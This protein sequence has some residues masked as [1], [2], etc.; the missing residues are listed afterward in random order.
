MTAEPKTIHYNG[1]EYE[2][3]QAH[4]RLSTAIIALE[5]GGMLLTVDSDDKE[6]VTGFVLNKHRQE[7]IDVITGRRRLLDLEAAIDECDVYEVK[8]IPKAYIYSI[9]HNFISKKEIK[10]CGCCQFG[11]IW[12]CPDGFKIQCHILLDTKFDLAESEM[13]T[14]KFP[15]C[16]L[17]LIGV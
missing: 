14:Y 11:Q 7:V 15:A 12:E 4:T 6:D 13:E 1:K 5:Q 9:D 10:S 2:I 17:K 3:V 8:E 16:P